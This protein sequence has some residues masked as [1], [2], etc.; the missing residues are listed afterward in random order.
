MHL[1]N[2]TVEQ[3]MTA[4]KAVL[5]G[6]IRPIRSVSGF[7]VAEQTI[8]VKAQELGINKTVRQL[9]QLEKKITAYNCVK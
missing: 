4:Y 3:A 8:F 9:S 6:Q 7:D 2:T 1:F 5:A